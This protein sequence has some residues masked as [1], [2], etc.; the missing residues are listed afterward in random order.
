MRCF[1]SSSRAYN[2]RLTLS[3]ITA[4]PNGHTGDSARAVAPST[5]ADE[6]RR[7]CERRSA[8]PVERRFQRRT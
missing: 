3:T 8:S 1:S 2:S 5:R 7:G 6:N 4:K